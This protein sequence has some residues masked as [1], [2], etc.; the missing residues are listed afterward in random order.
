MSTVSVV[1][2]AGAACTPAV[3]RALQTA[4]VSHSAD[5]LIVK[6]GQRRCPNIVIDVFGDTRRYFAGM[7]IRSKIIVIITI[8][9]V[10]GVPAFQVIEA[11][12]GFS[13]AACRRKSGQQHGSK[14]C[15]D[16]NNH[17]QFDQSKTFS[18]KKSIQHFNIP[19]QLMIEKSCFKNYCTYYTQNSG[20]IQCII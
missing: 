12:A 3:V 5:G 14:N 19:V 6:F 2:P 8:K 20:N 17:Q 7:S 10:H 16:G 1:D 11:V 18:V 15:N 9:P 4:V 13:S